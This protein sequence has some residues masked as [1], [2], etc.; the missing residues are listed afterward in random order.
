MTDASPTPEGWPPGCELAWNSENVWWQ[1]H[2]GGDEYVW[3]SPLGTGDD[4]KEAARLAAHA[5]YR[6]TRECAQWQRACEAEQALAEGLRQ[7][8]KWQERAANLERRLAE[9]TREREALKRAWDAHR[10]GADPLHPNGRC[11]CCGEGKCEWCKR[12]TD[13]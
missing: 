1:R 12:G 7:I 6:T 13:R 5:H 11:T 8:N 10:F 3:G 2:V 4:A 9:V